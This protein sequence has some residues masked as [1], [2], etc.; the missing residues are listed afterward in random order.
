MYIYIGTASVTGTGREGK[1][2]KR[3][4]VYRV[5]ENKWIFLFAS[6]GVVTKADDN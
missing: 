3:S 1:N 6:F 2:E 5:R 4:G